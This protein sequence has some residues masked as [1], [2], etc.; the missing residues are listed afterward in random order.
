MTRPSLQHLFERACAVFSVTPAQMRSARDGGAAR[1]AFCRIATRAG[2]GALPICM[3]LGVERA[4]VDS[5]V[6][7][8]DALFDRDRSFAEGCIEIEIECAAE[9]GVAAR[10][11]FA[12][13]VDYDVRAIALT[14]LD[15]PRAAMGVGVAQL[16]EL[17]AAF[18]AL[19]GDPSNTLSKGFE[20]GQN[21]E[22]AA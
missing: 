6:W 22:Q 3:K 15:G 13:P 2:Y 10:T 18:L 5:A 9:S 16:Q 12:L 1:L 8:A 20:N 14:I 4:A 17:A 21:P 11:A 7:Q 19:A